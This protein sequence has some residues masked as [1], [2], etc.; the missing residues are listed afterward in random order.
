MSVIRRRRLNTLVT[1][2]INAPVQDAAYGTET[3]NWV[4]L[5][6]TYAEVQD[7]IPS[8][9]ERVMEGVNLSNRPTRV[10]MDFCT[11]VT[12]AMRL[13]IGGRMLQIVGGPAELG[14]HEGIEILAE[15]VSTQGEAA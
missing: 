3:N 14:F 1:I 2:L 15:E 5:R 9:A 11:D 13:R 12:S 4:R 8:R 10:R 7:M 6:D